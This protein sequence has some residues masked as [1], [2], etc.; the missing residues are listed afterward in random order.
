MPSA[1]EK[2]LIESQRDALVAGFMQ[3]VGPTLKSV[4]NAQL[5]TEDLYDYLLFD[6]EVADD[7]ATSRVASAISSVQ[8]YM[9]RIVNGSEPGFPAVAASVVEMWRENDNQ[10]GDWAACEEVTDYPENYISPVT[11]QTKSHYFTDLETTLN[12]NRLDQ[13]RVQAAALGYLNEFEA[14]SNL[15]VLSGY[16]HMQDSTQDL[17][18]ATYYFV[19]RTTAKPYRYYWRSMDLS[20]NGNGGAGKPVTPNC[21]SDWLPIGLP[22]AG[23]AVLEKTVRPVF[24]NERL[25]I[26]WVERNPVR[27]K[28]QDGTEANT[29]SYRLYFGYKRFDDTWTAP[30]G[31]SLAGSTVSGNALSINELSGDFHVDYVELL[32]TTDFSDD[33]GVHGSNVY[34]RLMLGVFV[35]DFSNGNVNKPTVYGY[36]YCDSSFNE[37]NLIEDTRNKLFALFK[38]NGTGYNQ[39]PSGTI[40]T[41]QYPLYTHTYSIGSVAPLSDVNDIPVKSGLGAGN[42]HAA[43]TSDISCTEQWWT[44]IADLVHAKAG[45][46]SLVYLSGDSLWVDLALNA[47]FVNDFTFTV[48]ETVGSLGGIYAANG[49]FGYVPS[50][51]D[52]NVGSGSVTIRRVDIDNYVFVNTGLTHNPKLFT[53]QLSALQ[54]GMYRLSVALYFGWLPEIE[55]QKEKLRFYATGGDFLD[56][57]DVTGTPIKGSIVNSLFNMD[58]LLTGMRAVTTKQGCIVNGIMNL[59]KMKNLREYSCASIIWTANGSKQT[60]PPSTVAYGLS[61]SSTTS[62]SIPVSLLSPGTNDVY[63][64]LAVTDKESVTGND[65]DVWTWY[66][67]TVTSGDLVDSLTQPPQLKWNYDSKLGLAQYLD[68]C[69]PKLP[70]DTRLNTTF[71]RTLIAKARLGLD[72]LLDYALQIALLEAPLVAGD[73]P[74]PMDFNGANGLYFW[75][76]FFH[77]PFFVAWRFSNE[78]QFADAQS[79]LHYIF[80]PS[81]A[82]KANSAPD[83]WNVYPLCHSKGQYAYLVEDPLDPDAQ[84]Y[85]NPVIYQKAVFM[86]Y[87]SDLI[88]QGDA[89]YRQLTRDGLTQARVIYDLAA[90]LL[91]PR[92]DVTLSSAWVPQTLDALSKQSNSALRE[93]EREMVPAKEGI[94][95]LGG[96]DVSYLLLADNTN[97][98]APL[99]AYLLAYWDALDARLYNLRHNLTVD[100]KPMSLALYEAPVNRVALLE[101]RAQPGTLNSAGGAVSLTIPPYRFS[102]MLSRAYSAVAMLSS[103]GDSLLSLYERGDSARREELQ[104]QQLLDMSSYLLTLQQHTIDGLAR[105]DEALIASANTAAAR[106]DWYHDLYVKNISDTEQK[107]MD[108]HAGAEQLMTVSQGM[109]VAGG[110]LKIPPTIFG[111][112]DGGM[113][114]EGVVD[115]VANVMLTAGQVLSVTADRL[116]TS[117]SYRR[118]QED[119]KNQSQQADSEY[120]TVG[121]QRD[122]L[123][124]RATAA[125]LELTRVEAQQAQIKAVHTFLKTRVTQAALYQWLLGRQAALYYQVYDATLSLCLAAHACWQYE[126]G[127]FT[128][129]FIQPGAWNDRYYGLQAGQAL[130]LNLQQMEAAYLARHERRLEITRTVSLLE[131][132]GASAF[133]RQKKDGAF[134]FGLSELQ[135][136]KDYP[137]H[138]L[139]QIKSVAISLPGLLAPF[140]DIKATLMQTASSTLLNASIDGVNYLNGKSKSV[141][142]AQIVTN[143]RA[144]QQIALSSGLSDAGLFELNFGDERYLPFEGTGA[145]SNWVLSFPRYNKSMTQMA[146][147]KTLTDVIVHVRYTAIDGGSDFAAQVDK[148]LGN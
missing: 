1:L 146:F 110:A 48:D 147:L 19:G 42:L 127:D 112:A 139:R 35:R 79:W 23:D 11:R 113:R 80:D 90:E 126:T 8:T 68:F 43:N 114:L 13:D 92:P 130:Q 77:M 67:V 30:N 50:N 142:Q 140:Q 69:N 9:T 106:R 56:V 29:R 2:Q 82:N 59:A 143:L 109:M 101:Q 31:A 40:G 39:D 120:T 32:A 76:L 44:R 104:Q 20:K 61:A 96:R 58:C 62:L 81:A 125:Q 25:Y 122:A 6:P 66:K 87:V 71:V 55:V 17:N 98:I 33:G 119:W 5:T 128:S 45:A 28:N 57:L 136:D 10:Y 111:M 116:A 107:V 83:Y 26:A 14:V 102:A 47:D 99:N 88:D 86:A 124:V 54:D 137:G 41:L 97:F 132:A 135:F 141:G 21:W 27:D 145:V 3:F 52:G 60:D 4:G 15:Y 100:G 36:Q 74:E 37:R 65:D 49:G 133:E 18:K 103:F 46:S 51:G 118:R 115:A 72:S 34:G 89:W 63:I 94:V 121:K 70:A 117:E 16:I 78:Q 7:V 144:S 108:V 148:T 134:H 84:A 73:P 12:Q 85:A 38:D 131:I 64:C 95:D 105:D 123:S 138:Y 91:G 75:E 53:G 93:F 22:L 129:T 24:Y